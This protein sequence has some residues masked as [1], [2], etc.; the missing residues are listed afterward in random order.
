[1]LIYNDYNN[2]M[3]GKR[4]KQIRLLRSL[5]EKKVPVH[6]IGLQ[7]HYEIDHVP[8]KE[9]EDTLVAMRGWA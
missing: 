3:P 2:E 8:F 9:I 7:G 4:E 5:R 1:M 6:A